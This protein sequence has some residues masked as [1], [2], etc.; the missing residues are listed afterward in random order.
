MAKKKIEKQPENKDYTI[1]KW[2]DLPRYQCKLC[3]FDSLHEEVIIEHIWKAHY[4]PP[5]SDAPKK[6][7]FDR[8][9]NKLKN[10]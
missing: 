1:G 5:E 9:G 10:G 2:K 6:E 4:A 3:P 8:F 7:L